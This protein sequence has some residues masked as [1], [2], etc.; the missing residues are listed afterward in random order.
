MP[1]TKKRKLSGLS[2]LELQLA[3]SSLL[4]LKKIIVHEESEEDS[5]ADPNE[6][7]SESFEQQVDT[8]LSLLGSKLEG[9][10]V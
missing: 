7:A 2:E 6:P 4:K 10:Q 5:E 8:M 3:Y 1:H 9:P